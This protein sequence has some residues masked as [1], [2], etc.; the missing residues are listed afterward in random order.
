V[1]PSA[2]PNT[3]SCILS[4][5]PRCAVFPYTRSTRVQLTF[6]GGGYPGSGSHSMRTPIQLTAV[7]SLSQAQRARVCVS[8]K[9]SG[10]DP[11]VKVTCA[12]FSSFPHAVH[13]VGPRV[14]NNVGQRMA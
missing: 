14:Q 2:Q 9:A 5:T 6:R 3:P 8:L 4:T 12:A 13:G 1:L 7:A 11:A 10:A